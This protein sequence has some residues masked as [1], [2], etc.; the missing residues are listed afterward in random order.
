MPCSKKK[1]EKEY[2]VEEKADPVKY[3]QSLDLEDFTDCNSTREILLCEHRD[4]FEKKLMRD[5]E[6]IYEKYN[7]GFRDENFFGKDWEN[8]LGEAFANIIYNCIAQKHDLSLFY[9]C[10]SLAKDLFK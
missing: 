8:V 2:I 1:K 10:P 9:D 5:L 3:L 4:N 6:F 7:L